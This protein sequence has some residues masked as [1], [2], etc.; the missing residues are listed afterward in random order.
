VSPPLTTRLH[1]A[2]FCII[3]SKLC[4]FTLAILLCYLLQ[5]HPP[6]PH[7]FQILNLSNGLT[8]QT[9]GTIIFSCKAVPS[10]VP[11]KPHKRVA[12]SQL[13]H[14][15]PLV[16]LYQSHFFHTNSFP[17]HDPFSH[18][19][20][21]LL[22]LRF[23]ILPVEPVHIFPFLRLKAAFEHEQQALCRPFPYK[24]LHDY[25][26]DILHF[27]YNSFS[28]VMTC[29]FKSRPLFL[30]YF[31]HFIQPFPLPFLFF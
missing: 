5:R 21:I 2:F 25:D 18:P 7:P 26:F 1:L 30:F 16:C 17:F 10:F 24:P 14:F 22:N 23:L 15:S 11:G 20:I 13:E 28:P 8:R 12:L 31:F 29:F 9:S 3:F 19:S 27:P 6:V 4:V